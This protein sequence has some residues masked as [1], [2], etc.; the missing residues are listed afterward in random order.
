MMMVW[1]VQEVEGFS[2][3]HDVSLRDSL[4]SGYHVETSTLPVRFLIDGHSSC[5][6]TFYVR[7]T[8]GPSLLLVVGVVVG[9]VLRLV[10]QMSRLVGRS[11]PVKAG[12]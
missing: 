9:A 3:S 4:L 11:L 8:L 1:L 5:K 6:D 2:R 7:Y 12:E 10:R